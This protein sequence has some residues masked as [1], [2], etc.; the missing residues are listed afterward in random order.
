MKPQTTIARRMAIFRMV[1]FRMGLEAVAVGLEVEVMVVVVV[2]VSTILLASSATNMDMMLIA[3]GIDSSRILY[4][5]NLYNN[6][7]KFHLNSIIMLSLVL[8]VYKLSML[9]STIVS[10]CLNLVNAVISTHRTTVQ[11]LH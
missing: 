3:V 5:H 4:L 9:S 6:G 2:E 8:M 7:I 11:I 10:L 1:I